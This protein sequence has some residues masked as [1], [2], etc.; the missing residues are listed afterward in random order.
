MCQSTKSPFQDLFSKTKNITNS[1]KSCDSVVVQVVD[2]VCKQQHFSIPSAFDT[3]PAASFTGRGVF[4]IVSGRVSFRKI[5]TLSLFTNAKDVSFRLLSHRYQDIA[6]IRGGGTRTS[7]VTGIT[8]RLGAS[9]LALVHNSIFH[10]LRSTPARNFSFVF[11]SPPCTLGRLPRIPRLIFGHSL[12]QSKNVFI[13]RRPGAGS[14]SKLPCFCRRHICNSIGFSV[15]VGRRRGAST[16]A[17]QL[18]II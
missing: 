6:T 15:F 10:C 12:L 14:F 17:V 13:V 2:K 1:I 16:W 18:C 11:T 9:S 5:S 8:G 3:H 7:F 4:G